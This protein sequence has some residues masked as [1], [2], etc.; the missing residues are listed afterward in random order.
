MNSTSNSYFKTSMPSH[1]KAIT[2]TH[3]KLHRIRVG[4]LPL[5][6]ESPPVI[7]AVLSSAIAGFRQVGGKRQ[8]YTELQTHIID[9][10][11]APGTV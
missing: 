4:M 3:F 6:F 8:I 11:G 1:L 9:V 5:S 10:M 2:I 7:F